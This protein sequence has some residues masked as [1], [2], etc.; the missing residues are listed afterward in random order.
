MVKGFETY[1]RN[2]WEGLVRHEWQDRVGDLDAWLEANPGQRVVN[3]LVRTVSRVVVDGEEVYVKV[4]KSIDDGDGHFGFRLWKRFKWRFL[5]NRAMATLA[6]TAAMEQAGI[7]CAGAILAVRRTHGFSAEEVFISKSVP[8]PSVGK[9]VRGMTDTEERKAVLRNV[10]E[11]LCDFH[12][13][14]FLHGDCIPGN[15][16]WDGGHVHFIDN[17]R[18]RFVGRLSRHGARRNLVQFCFHLLRKAEDAAMAE[19]FLACYAEAMKT[20]GKVFDGTDAVM[21]KARRRFKMKE[22]EK[23]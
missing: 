12:C 3:R 18:T 15:L 4:V 5:E 2:G 8:Y 22:G 19:H 11:G 17:D 10:A 20:R 14:G 21:A 13:R 9:I 6:V 7:R 23:R 1:S 16:L